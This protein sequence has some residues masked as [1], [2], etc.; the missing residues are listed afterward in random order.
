MSLALAVTRAVSSSLSLISLLRSSISSSFEDSVVSSSETIPLRAVHSRS[1]ALHL[2]GRAE[3]DLI[4][5]L[6]F[7]KVGF[8]VFLYK[9][10]RK[11]LNRNPFSGSYTFFLNG[12][13]V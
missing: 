5:S 11:L 4:A 9:S 2:S 12:W 6:L 3:N 7:F 13:F 1:R 10:V 8:K